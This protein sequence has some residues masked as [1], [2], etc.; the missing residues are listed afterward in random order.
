[1]MLQRSGILAAVQPLVEWL[2][3]Q[4]SEPMEES[5]SNLKSQREKLSSTAKKLVY[6]ENAEAEDFL[7]TT[8]L[9]RLASDHRR[10]VPI[11][12]VVGAKGSG[13][14]YTFLQIIRRKNWHVFAQDACA[15]DVEIK[16]AI[17]HQ[18]SLLRVVKYFDYI[19]FT[20]FEKLFFLVMDVFNTP[21]VL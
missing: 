8:P 7:P 10:Q 11:T 12:V 13:K 16:A 14:T 3:H 4:R 15:S 20:F 5:P 19:P 21:Q 6:A 2:P 17:S 18:S 1:M 9:R